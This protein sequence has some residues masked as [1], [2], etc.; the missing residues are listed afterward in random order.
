M[1]ANR[2]L[3]SG[4]AL[5]ASTLACAQTLIHVDA[6]KQTASIPSLIYGAGAEDVNH[7]IYGGL[8]DQR[9]FGESFEEP[10]VADVDGFEAF[11]APWSVD[12]GVLSV[13]TSSHG[14]IVLR[15]APQGAKRI[16]VEVRPNT[17]TAIS[18]LIVNVSDPING[19]DGFRGYEISLNTAKKVLVVGKHEHNWQPIAEVPADIAPGRWTLLSVEFSGGKAEISVDG[20]TLYTLADPSPLSGGSVG[21]RSFDGGASFRTLMTDDTEV[22][23]MP[24]PTGVVGFR[25][26]DAAWNVSG[27][28]IAT[29]TQA[30]AKII[31]NSRPIAVGDAE[32]E[33]R[34]TD[35]KSI[36]G[37]IFHVSEAGNGADNFRGYEISLDAAKQALVVGKH[38]HDWQPIAE[39]PVQFTPGEW[40]RLGVKFNGA[41]F[42]VEINGTQTYTYTDSRAPLTEGKVGLR[43]FDGAA[44]FRNLTINGDAIFPAPTPVGVSAMWEPIGQAEFSRITSGAFH[45]EAFQSIRGKA[46]DG[47]A[48]SGLNK[49]GIGVTKG[50]TMQGS[51]YLRGTCKNAVVTLQS[52]DG[53]IEYACTE[54]TGISP[55]NWQKHTFTLTP[56]ASDSDAR[57]AL[58]LGTDGELH[59]DMAMLHTSSFPF[60]SDITEAFRNEGLTFLRYGGTM[61]NAPQYMT[62]NM[63]GPHDLR[64]PY[65]GHWYPYSTNGFGI[66]EFVE[67]A[68]LIGTEP[69]FAIN[70]EDDP[71]YVLA[72]LKEIEPHGLKYIEIG[73]EENIFDDSREAYEHYVERFHTL[74][75]AIRPVYPSLVFINAAWWRADRTDLM[76]YVFHELDGK[77]LL[78]DYHPWTDEVSQ[79][80]AVKNDL[81]T[82]RRLFYKWN[83]S[84]D[85][86][87]AILEENGNTHSL[88]R[89]LSHAVVLNIVR[90]MDGFVELDSPANAL[91][92][93]LQNDNGWNQG[94]IFFN[95]STVWCQPPYYA[96]QMAASYHQPILVES[97]CR[98]SSLD[99]SATRNEEGDLIVLHIVNSSSR[100]QKI[101]ADIAGIESVASVEGLVLSSGSLTDRN[102]PQEPEKVVPHH[103]TAPDPTITLEPYS[104]TVMAISCTPAS[105]TEV[106]PDSIPAQRYYS[107]SGTPA[108]HPDKG[109]YITASGKKI[110]F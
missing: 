73:N 25:H 36:I 38:D 21:L 18:G 24:V 103:F 72:L 48:N 30:H 15:N 33:L 69:T 26:F 82:M 53:T 43:T 47:I 2:Y 17:V 70:I 61:V 90:G 79:A 52:S 28:E 3:L 12:E 76:E 80:K 109:I 101:T 4:L 50:E 74:Y 66:V 85:M 97:T 27:N 45:G 98:S 22:A 102:T 77:S 19:A 10:S 71:A 93:Y 8:Y 7:E 94:Q 11:D 35:T 106:I 40:H 107:I 6:T 34:H 67:F 63:T 41:S 31:H 105:V 75:D 92:P 96:Q 78:W 62:A 55:D 44:S 91:E 84:T 13:A 20:K 39:V 49:W 108:A 100:P 65:T 9:I 83:P 54:I 88:H 99:I 14:K 59:A 29:S 89:A 16:A 1:K 5:A 51:V 56:D 87:V 37:L 95:S 46:S 32:V 23:F 86:R 110:A 58:L 68:R 42:S 57:F 104:Y 60:R 64:P 81:E